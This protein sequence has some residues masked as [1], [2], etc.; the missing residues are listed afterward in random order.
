MLNG[1]GNLAVHSLKDL[2]TELPVGLKLGAVSQRADVRDV[3]IRR[4]ADMDSTSATI[5]SLP[6]GATVA[7]SSTRRRAQL[8]Y[9]RPDLK[10]VEIRGNVGTRLRKLSE[11][12]EFTAIILAAAGLE[13]L[14]FRIG[15]SG[16]LSG[17]DV[18]SGLIAT[19]I[20]IEEM[21]PCVRAG[22]TGH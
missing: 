19:P 20:P 4:R 7:T 16:E 15:N 13:R 6:Q 21:L 14:H 9:R 2:P 22:R 3:L 12:P 1:E 11:Q 5:D 8:L 18:P 17:D 10:T